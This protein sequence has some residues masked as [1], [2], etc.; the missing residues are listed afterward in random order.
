MRGGLDT[1]TLL[2]I[3]GAGGGTGGGRE[4]WSAQPSNRFAVDLSLGGASA[5]FSAMR[6]T[7]W[8]FSPRLAHQSRR[9]GTQ[10]DVDRT[11]AQFT[12]N[13]SCQAPSDGD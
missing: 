3:A 11:F 12:R 4:N 1:W 13:V 2:L 8:T 5:R 9:P 6:R 10:D 7:I